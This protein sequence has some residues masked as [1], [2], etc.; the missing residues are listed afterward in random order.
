MMARVASRG[1]GKSSTSGD[2]LDNFEAITNGELAS[3]EFGRG[4][5]FAVMLDDHAAREK[6][7]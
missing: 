3:G 4:H 1:N 7:S 6:L 2:D 5:G